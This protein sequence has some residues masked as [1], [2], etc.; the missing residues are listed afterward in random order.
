MQYNRP[1]INET[2]LHYTHIHRRIDRLTRTHK[3]PK[4]SKQQQMVFDET[5]KT[6]QTVSVPEHVTTKKTQN[7]TAKGGIILVQ[8]L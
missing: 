5:N 7:A 6:K 4:T 1:A 3:H 8:K 2:H